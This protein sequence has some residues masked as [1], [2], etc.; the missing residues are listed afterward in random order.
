MSLSCTYSEDGDANW[1]YTPPD[2]FTPFQKSKRK[3]CC[4]CKELIDIGALSLKFDCW[5]YP[6]DDIEDRIYGDGG[7]IPI[8]DKFLC[9][10]C[11]DQYMNLSELG[12]CIDPTENVMDLLQEYVENYGRKA[13]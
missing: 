11:G 7:E 4:S 9:E 10:K 12:F 2:D 5:R 8:A 1:Y 13:A 3:R 6:K